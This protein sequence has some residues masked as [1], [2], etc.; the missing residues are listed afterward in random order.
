MG[1]SG[2]NQ[3]RTLRASE[4]ACI[5][6]ASFMLGGG[7]LW[8]QETAKP[9]EKTASV[10]EY[11]RD[12]C[13]VVF[14]AKLKNKIDLEIMAPENIQFDGP[15]IAAA[16]DKVIGTI[17][18]FSR[19]AYTP[20]NIRT[21]AN[22]FRIPVMRPVLMMSYYMT[23]EVSLRAYTRDEGDNMAFVH[24]D[25]IFL[26]TDRLS[27]PMPKILCHIATMGAKSMWHEM[28]TV[29]VKSGRFQTS[30]WFD[31]GLGDYISLQVAQPPCVI[32][33]RAQECL[34]L[35]R[36]E[37]ER[38]KL[39][40]YCPG[41]VEEKAFLS[42]AKQPQLLEGQKVSLGAFL[43][44]EKALGKEKLQALVKDLNNRGYWQDDSLYKKI[45]EALGTDIRGLKPGDLDRVLG[46]EPTSVEEGVAA[47]SGGA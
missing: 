26:E 25:L 4:A 44:L 32:E 46:P 16:Y 14:K 21:R 47:T 7:G 8:A 29:K 12:R 38:K 27:D 31:I 10:S 18:Q 6:A 40:D 33:G 39:W 1:L 42:G 17:D 37:E 9:P 20:N 15:A 35:F 41:C 34:A 43:Y 30:G 2:L 11:I 13:K 22:S 5:L 23:K 19:D 28:G 45:K 24:Y 36:Q 3:R